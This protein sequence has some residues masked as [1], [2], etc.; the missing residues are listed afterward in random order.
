MRV[1]LPMTLNGLCGALVAGGVPPGPGYAVTPGLREAYRSGDDEELE[2]VALSAAAR[3]S[4]GLLAG[5]DDG[6]GSG[7]RGGDGAARRV[8]LA[9]DVPAISGADRSAPGAVLVLDALPWAVVAAALVDDV[10]AEND[11]RAAMRDWARAEAG[12]DDA[13]FTLD[14]VSD[15]ELLWWAAQEIGGLCQPGGR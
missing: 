12:D 9:V 14:A 6:G 1:Y 8:V 11:V 2:Y 3:A 5:E 4:I 10:G 13:R 15:H 7:S